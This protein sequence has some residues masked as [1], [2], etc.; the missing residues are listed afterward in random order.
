[1]LSSEEP[2]AALGR[3]ANAWRRDLAAYVIGVTGSVGKTTTKDLLAAM[4]APHR[5]LV[6]SR[7]NFNTEI[8]LPLELL[9][10][11]QGTELIVLE[12]AMRGAGQIAELAADR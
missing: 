6:S 2:V 7:G 3:L 11:P 4:L 10:A 5:K 12:M 1:M 8:G 9:G